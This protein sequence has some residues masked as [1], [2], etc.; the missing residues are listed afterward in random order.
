MKNNMN[1]FIEPI[2]ESIR[3]IG[4]YNKDLAKDE[5]LNEDFI[6]DAVIRRIKVI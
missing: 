5:F 2:L 1:I 6:Q 3:L 4:D